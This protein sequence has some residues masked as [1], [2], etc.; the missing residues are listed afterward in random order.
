MTEDVIERQVEFMTDQVDRIYM[1]DSNPWTEEQYKAELK[2][3]DDWAQAELA[4]LPRSY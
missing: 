2:K 3:I 1:K 4:K